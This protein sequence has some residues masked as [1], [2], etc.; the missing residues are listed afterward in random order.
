MAGTAR[1]AVGRKT[2]RIAQR[3]EQSAHNALVLGSN[4]SRPTKI[5]WWY[6]IMVSTGACQVPSP[7]S[8]L[9]IIANLDIAQLGRAFA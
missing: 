6:S 1:A 9:G 7:S 2:G 4:P 5:K 8:T 3:S